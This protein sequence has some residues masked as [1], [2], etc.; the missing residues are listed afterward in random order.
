MKPPDPSVREGIDRNQGD[1]DFEFSLLLSAL[2]DDE[3]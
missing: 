2:P 1:L 3:Q